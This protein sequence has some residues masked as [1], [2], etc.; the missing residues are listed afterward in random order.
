MGTSPFNAGMEIAVKEIDAHGPIRGDMYYNFYANQ[1]M[2]QHG[3]PPWVSWTKRLSHELTVTQETRGH[4]EG[5]WYFGHGDHGGA[6]GGRLY[7]TAMACLCLE[8]SFRHLPVF[9]KHARLRFVERLRE[10]EQA[11]LEAENGLA[12]QPPAEN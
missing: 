4:L 10:L 3:G 9:R 5:S 8:E 2:F 6:A 7:A 11:K 1:V 12:G